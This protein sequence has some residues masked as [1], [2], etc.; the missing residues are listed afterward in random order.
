MSTD[1]D[2]VAQLVWERAFDALGELDMLLGDGVQVD[3]VYV[4]AA[5]RGYEAAL[6]YGASR[7]RQAPRMRTRHP[8][9]P[10][11]TGFEVPLFPEM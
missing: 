4:E 8:L 2:P 5:T 10:G 3:P 1:H 7:T 9:N 6:I 11:F